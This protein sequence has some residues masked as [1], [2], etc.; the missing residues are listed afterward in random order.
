MKYKVKCACGR[1]L[2]Y[3]IDGDDEYMTVTVLEMCPDCPEKEFVGEEDNHP[4]RGE[5]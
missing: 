2:D 3:E 4:G 5:R 1:E